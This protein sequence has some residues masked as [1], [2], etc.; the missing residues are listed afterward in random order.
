[1]KFI[2]ILFVA[3]IAAAQNIPIEQCF[4]I[5]QIP[6]QE[7]ADAEALFLQ[8]M[9]S[10]SLYTV[11]GAV[12]PM[13]GGFTTFRLPAYSL[14]ASKV[15]QARRHLEAF[16]CGEEIVATVH[17]F[18]RLFP[19]KDSK[20]LERYFDAIVF[21]RSGLRRTI[22]EHKTFFVPLGLSENAHPLEVLLAVEYIE[23]P[24][25]FR[26]FGYL[27]GYPDYAVDFFFSAS[28]QQALN[29]TFVARDFV[30]MPTFA[31]AE[32][33]VVYAIEKGGIEREDDHILRRKLAPILAEY[34]RRR[35]DF[36]G[37]G[38]PGIVAL[39]RNWFCS[40]STCQLPKT[41]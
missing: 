25:R 39:L 17:H 24:S 7:R 38:K 14:D 18:A 12:K 11:I 27:Y 22:Q 13:S 21:H 30:S 32:R 4:P 35:A 15:D 37:E 40:S 2:T 28:R 23:G 36:I 33:G 6:T 26:G 19:N 20:T 1:M 31:R 41:H 16:R 29:G 10:E 3:S 8:L 34:T 9:D 5:E